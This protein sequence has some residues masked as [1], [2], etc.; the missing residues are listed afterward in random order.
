MVLKLSCYQVIKCLQVIKINNNLGV[1]LQ[2]A[3]NIIFMN[4]LVG[5]KQEVLTIENQASL[6]FI[7]KK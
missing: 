4:P 6:N 3:N 7:F 1:N 5:K 2:A